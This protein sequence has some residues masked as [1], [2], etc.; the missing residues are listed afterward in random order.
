VNE[1][2]LCREEREKQNE[3]MAGILDMGVLATVFLC[4]CAGIPLEEYNR[5]RSN[6]EETKALLEKTTSNLESTHAS[7][8]EARSMAEEREAGIAVLKT[9]AG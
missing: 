7:L 5:L 3:I 8:E 4:G 6:L 1:A 2:V 9:S